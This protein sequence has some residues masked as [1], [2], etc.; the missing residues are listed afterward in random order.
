[1]VFG[2]CWERRFIDFASLGYLFYYRRCLSFLLLFFFLFYFLLSM[3]WSSRTFVYL[4]ISWL[5]CAHRKEI[6]K[7][8]KRREAEGDNNRGTNLFPTGFSQ[9]LLMKRLWKSRGK[10]RKPIRFSPPG[11]AN[12]LLSARISLPLVFSHFSFANSPILLSPSLWRVM[13]NG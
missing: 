8:R 10:E 11:S 4:L 6:G 12:D 7:I 9:W 3:G 13:K 1:M 2:N 5:C